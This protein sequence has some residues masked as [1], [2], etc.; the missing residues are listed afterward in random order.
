MLQPG[1]IEKS[2][3][4]YVSTMEEGVEYQLTEQALNRINAHRKQK[5]WPEIKPFI[6]KKVNNKMEIDWKDN[7][8]KKE[9]F[10]L[11]SFEAFALALP[12][13][14]FALAQGEF[15]KGVPEFIVQHGK[16]YKL[17]EK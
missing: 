17:I 7:R 2:F 5:S 1:D 6:F 11:E 10:T 15:Q 8:C 13:F 14:A 3:Q 9:S 16:K 12:F 4:H